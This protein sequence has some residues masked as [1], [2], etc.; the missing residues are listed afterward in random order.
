[1]LNSLFPQQD[2]DIW[3]AVKEERWG[4]G[5]SSMFH[6]SHLSR[7][8]VPIQEPNISPKK[9]VPLKHGFSTI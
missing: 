4:G 9:K 1:M 7:T 5:G 2:I 3:V 8:V 6:T